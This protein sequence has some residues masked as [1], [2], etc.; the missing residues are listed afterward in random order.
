MYTRFKKCCVPQLWGHNTDGIWYGTKVLHCALGYCLLYPQLCT[1]TPKNS[2]APRP[3]SVLL[4]QTLLLGRSWP[5][6]HWVSTWTWPDFG[7]WREREGSHR[8]VSQS[9]RS[10]GG[11]SCLSLSDLTFSVSWALLG[12]QCFLFFLGI[13]LSLV[14]LAVRFV[15]G[16]DVQESA[17]F[18]C[19]DHGSQL[20]AVLQQPT[21][22]WWRYAR[23]ALLLLFKTGTFSEMLK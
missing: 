20:A 23:R 12:W 7:V 6:T 22:R 18:L 13:F 2:G 1:N 16:P 10:C 5:Y 4:P 15:T 11:P 17:W 19:L 21:E 3:L 14:L 9:L 8:F